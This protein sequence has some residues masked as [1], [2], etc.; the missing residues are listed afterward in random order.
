MFLEYF[1]IKKKKETTNDATRL[2]AILVNFNRFV[3]ELCKFWLIDLYVKNVR[4]NIHCIKTKGVFL[5]DFA[6][7]RGGLNSICEQK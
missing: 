3:C 5:A 2:N 7:F 4:I 1:S 6:K